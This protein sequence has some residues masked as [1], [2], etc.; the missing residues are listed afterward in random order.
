MAFCNEIIPIFVAFIKGERK[1]QE[2]DDDEFVNVEYFTIDELMDKIYK[3]EITDSKTIA[4]LMAY[5]NK[6][7]K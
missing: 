6:Y 1:E 7:V 3:M 2:L 4:S 5:K